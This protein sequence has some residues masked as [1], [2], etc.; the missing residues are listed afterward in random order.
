MA[1]MTAVETK[2]FLDTAFALVRG[3]FGNVDYVYI[4]G[5]RVFGGSG[6]GERVEVGR[7]RPASS[8]DFIGAIPLFLEMGRLLVPICDSGWG[9]VHGEDVTHERG[10]NS[11]RE[12]VDK[13]VFVGDTSEGDTVLK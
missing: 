13:D 4:H 11:G 12:V 2:S 7:G 3:K 1:G 10:K 5:V 6:S 9:S 8:S